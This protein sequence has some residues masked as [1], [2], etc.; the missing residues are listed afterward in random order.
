MGDKTMAKRMTTD[1]FDNPGA[2]Q[3][4]LEMVAPP[5][6]VIP[7]RQ[8]PFFEQKTPLTSLI[9]VLRCSDFVHKSFFPLFP[10]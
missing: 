9:P 4:S 2:I 8:Y 1:P 6:F 7:P 5:L 3:L 10:P